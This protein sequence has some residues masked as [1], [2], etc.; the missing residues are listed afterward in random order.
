MRRVQIQFFRSSLHSS[1]IK[2]SG[3]SEPAPTE[4]PDVNGPPTV[5]EIVNILAR[6]M[7]RDGRPLIQVTLPVVSTEQLAEQ[8][9]GLKLPPDL[10]AEIRVID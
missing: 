5:G 4:V 2:A 8:L 6:R 1:L 3:A 9:N 7:A 10:A